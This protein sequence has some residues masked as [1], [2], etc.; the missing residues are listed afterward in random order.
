MIVKKTVEIEVAFE[1]GPKIVEQPRG[2]FRG[3]VPEPA[4]GADFGFNV[5]PEVEEPDGARGPV[6]DAAG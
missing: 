2:T 4:V 5:L 1:G 6:V 3:G